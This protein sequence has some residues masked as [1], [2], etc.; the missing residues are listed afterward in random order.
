MQTPK[1][2]QQERVSI[3][4][5][6]QFCFKYEVKGVYDVHSHSNTEF[7][8]FVVAQEGRSINPSCFPMGIISPN[9]CMSDLRLAPLTGIKPKL[10]PF[11]ATV[12]DYLLSLL[13]DYDYNYDYLAFTVI[14]HLPFSLLFSP[15]HS[16]NFTCLL[17]K[18]Y[19]FHAQTLDSIKFWTYSPRLSC[20]QLTTPASAMLAQQAGPPRQ[21]TLPAT[22]L[23]WT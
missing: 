13:I 15:S 20:E 10:L 9:K 7:Q 8:L 19:L 2:Q 5:D 1:T 3:F 16:L 21:S 12:L 4:S 6:C 22:C 11:L 14:Y 18:L 17:N 23:K